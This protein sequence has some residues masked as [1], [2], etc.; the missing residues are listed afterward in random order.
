MN[1]SVRDRQRL[2]TAKEINLYRSTACSRLGHTSVHMSP[3]AAVV[4]N[5]G[6]S[7]LNDS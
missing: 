2:K 4:S 1:E 7:S 5:D 3:R 6:S